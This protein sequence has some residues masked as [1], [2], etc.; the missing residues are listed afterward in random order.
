MA[1]V[2]TSPIVTLIE[3]NTYKLSACIATDP[4]GRNESPAR[5][6]PRVAIHMGRSVYMICQHGRLKHR[7]WGVHGDIDVIPAET[8]CVWEPRA[9]DTALIVGIDSELLAST[10]EEWKAHPKDLELVDRFQI[11]DPQI[12]NICWALKAE[13]EAGYP[14]GRIFLDSLA[15]ALAAAL[16]ARHSSLAGAPCSSIYRI[17]GHRLRRA[18]SYIEDNLKND[19][20][21]REIAQATGV[22]VSHLKGTFRQATGV[23]VHQYVIQRRVERAKALLF[24]SSLPIHQIAYETGF[25]HQSHLAN[26]M[27]RLLGFSPKAVRNL[28]A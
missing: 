5:P 12:E 3:P 13:V 22:S 25:A 9:H 17:S 4:P 21:L 8:P 2:S 1:A 19:L 28:N 18:L 16:V 10:A 20:S 23:P 15:T 11:R 24:G 14:T 7:G 26:H 6:R 27:R